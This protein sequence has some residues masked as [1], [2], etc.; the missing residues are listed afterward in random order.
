VSAPRECSRYGVSAS[1]SGCPPGN[2]QNNNNAC[3]AA[4]ERRVEE[5]G[6]SIIRVIEDRLRGGQ[7]KAWPRQEQVAPT[8]TIID[9]QLPSQQGGE[10]KVIESRKKK[11]KKKK[12]KKAIDRVTGSQVNSAGKSTTGAQ[13]ERQTDYTPKP[14]DAVLTGT[15]MKTPKGSSISTPRKAVLPRPPRS[16]AVTLTLSEEA[17][18]SYVEALTTARGKIPLRGG[19]YKT[20]MRKARTD[21]IVLEV[22]GD[23]DGEMAS[24]LAT[25]LAQ[26]LDP[27][28][29]KVAAPARMAELRVDGI[30][31]S[32]TKE[33]L[34][35]ALALAA[36][37]GGAEV[38]VGE[39][40]TSSG[41]LGSAWVR[42]SLV[43]ARKLAQAGR[44]ALGWSTARVE[45]IAKRHLQCFKC[46]ELAQE[47]RACRR[48]TGRTYA[49]GVV[50][51]VIVPEAVLLRH[52]S[53]PSAIFLEHLRPTGWG[54]R[55]AVRR[56]GRR[57]GY[58]QLPWKRAQR[59]HRAPK[60]E[61]QK[62]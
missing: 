10:W 23:K 7:P 4:L 30:D 31:I 27:A 14:K 13:P 35:N 39:I 55:R 32:I 2:G 36:G 8:C 18:I 20:K 26:V 57:R 43:G 15:S 60:E 41:D 24:A 29:V 54:E 52:P 38:Q 59:T 48:W 40:G 34:R 12:A 44:T 25:R 51:P 47:R 42:C 28:T 58:Y 33:E 45:A 5:I 56:G 19:I 22:L 1:E 17:K 46:L 61:P 9:T 3:L 49:I 16:S 11:K 50:K 53:A 21:A 6:P 37:C 62:P